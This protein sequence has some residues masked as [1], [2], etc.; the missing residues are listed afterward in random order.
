MPKFILAG[1][2]R[3][4]KSHVEKALKA[5][6]ARFGDWQPILM[7][8]DDNK[9]PAISQKLAEKILEEAAKHGGA[10]VFGVEARAPDF[11]RTIRDH[12][13]FRRVSAAAVGKTGGG[14]YEPL[15]EELVAAF[16]EEQYWIANIKPQDYNSPLVLPS[17][18]KARRDLVPLWELAESYNS[19]DNLWAAA[20]L[21]GTFPAA[22]RRKIPRFK[23]DPWVCER[24]WIWRDDGARHGQAVFPDDWKYS[25]QLDDG[26]HFDVE[27]LHKT[28]TSFSD[29]AGKSH[30]L[31]KG[32]L[33]VTAQ[34]WIRGDKPKADT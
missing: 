8:G 30:G 29:S 21:I 18:F 16:D 7:Q 14:D 25:Y 26:F 13:R 15:I 33:N 5:G 3:S 10:H 34:G 2:Q 31:P 27:C 6:A 23:K 22:H 24:D 19:L 1:F 11:A 17:I 28:K 12:F 9:L 20:Q 32:Y 4:L